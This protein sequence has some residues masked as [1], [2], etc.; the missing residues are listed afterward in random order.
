MPSFIQEV[1]SAVPAFVGYTHKHRRGK[2]SLRYKPTRVASIA[3]YELL[4]G[5]PLSATISLLLRSDNTPDG[6]ITIAQPRS[7]MYHCLH[8]YFANGGGPC[9]IVSAGGYHATGQAQTTR[10]GQLGK[11]LKALEGIDEA[12]LLCLPDA[13][14]L[15]ED[16]FFNLSKEA[17]RQSALLKD[18]FALLDVQHPPDI[19]AQNSAHF[20]TAFR[21]GIGL[22]HLRYGAA[23]FPWIR[24]GQVPFVDQNDPAVLSIRGGTGLPASLVLRS[25][26]A[27]DDS[28]FHFNR[29]LYDIIMSAVTHSNVALPPSIAAA[30]TCV[31][32]DQKHGVWKA[33]VNISLKNAIAPLVTISTA[34]AEELNIDLAEGKSINLIRTFPNKGTMVWGARTLAGNDNEWRYVSVQRFCNMIEESSKKGIEPFVVYGSNATTWSKVRSLMENYLMQ[35]L[36]RGALAGARPE[37]AFYVRIGPGQTMTQQDILEGRMI[38]EVGVAIVRPAE[39]IVLRFIH[40][41][42]G[43]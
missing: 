42:Q 17:L 18:R 38:T 7:F 2:T 41:M 43:P 29:A 3:D 22:E 30:I 32:V 5:G 19:T 35:L 21:K 11:A 26:A 12:T 14:L 31:Q 24:T 8:F 34:Q 27:G 13:C 15:K 36:R 33:P 4:F 23:Y 10:A 37:H 25:E 9:Y 20:T 6:N 39:F 28:L 40:Q 16:S 1:S